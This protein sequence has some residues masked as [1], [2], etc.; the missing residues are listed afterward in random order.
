[1]QVTRRELAGILVPAAVAA[2]TGAPSN[3]ADELKAAEARLKAAADALG[4]HELPMSTEPAFQF[5]AGA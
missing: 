1:M 4:R 5:R 3:P 2:Q